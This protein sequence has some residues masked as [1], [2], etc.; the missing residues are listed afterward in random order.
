MIRLNVEQVYIENHNAQESLFCLLENSK[1]NNTWI[2]GIHGLF[3]DKCESWFLLS[4]LA[5]MARELDVSVCRFDFRGSGDSTG[6][7]MDLS[8][9]D[10]FEDG[11]LII[12]YVSENYKPSKIILLGVGFG[13]L[14]ATK[15][16]ID[17]GIN[18]IILI[19]PTFEPVFDYELGLTESARFMLE[20]TG[21]LDLN[22]NAIVEE[23][24]EKLHYS[25]SL[26]WNVLGSQISKRLL[27]EIKHANL[28][29]YFLTSEVCN[30][31][32]VLSVVNEQ[33]IQTVSELVKRS[34]NGR[35]CC[36]DSD[37]LFTHPKAQSEVVLKVR[38]WLDV[39]P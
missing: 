11:A 24:L 31:L 7:L 29:D 21:T 1:C 22:R 28:R 16:A 14:V 2:I 32:V 13:C 3:Q 17:A 35:L 9:R 33:A 20:Q 37:P 26:Y 8:L 5:R 15:L 25:G 4:K 19:N 36:I 27:Q 23:W 10:F 39:C 18:D 30:W 6:D 12:N 34:K 38:E